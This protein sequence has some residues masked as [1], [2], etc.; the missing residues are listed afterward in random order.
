M[1]LLSTNQRRAASA[2]KAL[3]RVAALSFLSDAQLALLASALQ[4]VSLPPGAPLLRKGEAWGLWRCLGLR[5]AA[6]RATINFP[7]GPPTEAVSI[8]T[9]AKTTP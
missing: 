6:A 1:A 3:R 4:E 7:N 2:C 5:A 8:G 9:A